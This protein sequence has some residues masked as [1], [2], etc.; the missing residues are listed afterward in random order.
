MCP[1][2]QVPSMQSATVPESQQPLQLIATLECLIFFVRLCVIQT[3]SLISNKSCF[4]PV[5]AHGETNYNITD[6]QN[7]VKM[8]VNIT[9]RRKKEIPTKVI[10]YEVCVC[11]KYYLWIKLTV[12]FFVLLMWLWEKLDVDKL[13]SMKNMGE[14]CW[15]KSE[16]FQHQW[17]SLLVNQESLIKRV[18]VGYS[19]ESTSHLSFPGRVNGNFSRNSYRVSWAVI[20]IL[21]IK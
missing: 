8:P 20:E 18:D 3:K 14:S 4:K 17:D 6:R 13:T 16:I 2:G 15:I 11:I 9:K 7:T 12:D 5:A 19:E 1:S 21:L 10:L